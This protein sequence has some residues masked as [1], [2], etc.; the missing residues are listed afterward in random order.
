MSTFPLLLCCLSIVNCGLILPK[1]E[2]HLNRGN[3]LEKSQRSTSNIFEL[4]SSFKHKLLKEHHNAVSQKTN[5]LYSLQKRDVSTCALDNRELESD[6]VELKETAEAVQ[7]V[8][9]GKDIILIVASD[10]SETGHT[11]LWRGEVRKSLGIFQ[12]T[13]DTRSIKA[14]VYPDSLQVSSVEPH[15][16]VI[17]VSYSHHLI[18][19]SRNYGVNWDQYTTPTTDFDPVG[20]LYMSKQDPRHLMIKSRGGDLFVSDT[21]GEHWNHV[22]AQVLMAELG[23]TDQG[24]HVYFMTQAGI[25][26]SNPLYRMDISS[27]NKDVIDRSTYRFR[28]DNRYLF[29]SRKNT[30]NNKQADSQSRRLYVS[31][32]YYTHS[33]KVGFTEVQL[34]SLKNQ[35]FYAVMATHETGAFIHVYDGTDSTAGNLYVSD[36]SGSKFGLSLTDHLFK[37]QEYPL[38]HYSVHDFYEVKSTRGVYITTTV[39]KGDGGHVSKITF[40]NGGTWQK[41]KAPDSTNCHLPDCS[42]HLHLRYSQ[43]ILPFYNYSSL[44]MPFSIETAPGIILAHGSVGPIRNN[45]FPKLYV[46][47]DSGHT[48]YDPDLP[49]GTY[50]YGIG[51]YGNI[52]TVAPDSENVPYMWFSHNR[53]K[54]FTKKQFDSTTHFTTRGIL[55][56]P[57]AASLFGFVMGVEGMGSTD[58]WRINAVNFQS[59][60]QRPCVADDYALVTEHEG[61]GVCILGYQSVYNLTKEESVC[62]NPASYSY[63]PVKSNK[64]NCDYSD[65]ECDYGFK[66]SS[67]D[68]CS[69]IPNV[70]LSDVCPPGTDTYQQSVSGF[71]LIPGDQCVP[72][73]DSK[74]LVATVTKQCTS[75]EKQSGIHPVTF[76]SMSTAGKIVGGIFI[77]LAALVAAGLTLFCWLKCKSRTYTSHDKVY[78]QRLP[79]HETGGRFSANDDTSSDE[80]ILT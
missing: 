4:P 53:G 61:M 17:V 75:H 50:S 36:S 63:K 52:I 43:Y 1:D 20:S 10:K 3:R 39:K 24:E 60:L 71:R 29:I 18:F 57:S 67:A 76:S 68:K 13:D 28:V 62:Y 78:Y 59:L 33:E 14:T 58:E 40:N 8:W 35:Q 41:L 27:R 74:K 21:L 55:I 30:T 80:D 7:A 22:A 49:A 42:L 77:V 51:D 54:C 56:D 11:T 19:V 38:G 9:V 31:S 47:S 79:L 32:N 26:A 65:L 64:C 16:T 2:L 69:K 44:K 45:S 12:F 72:T 6:A 37:V 15:D 34:P 66:R 25:S 5:I 73:D 70:G 48:W 23:R 46:S